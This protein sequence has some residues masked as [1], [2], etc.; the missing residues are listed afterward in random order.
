MKSYDYSSHA[1]YYDVVEASDSFNTFNQFL[2]NLFHKHNVKSVLDMTCGTGVQ[3]IFLHD[4]G[5][6][7]TA[8]DLSG[9]MISMAREKLGDRTDLQFHQANMI[10][11]NFNKQFEAVISMF[12]AIGHLTREDFRKTVQNAWNNLKSGGLYIFDIFN[13]DWMKENFIPHEFMDVCMEHEGTKYVRFNDNNLDFNTH[14]LHINQKTLIQTGIEKIREI[15]QIWDMQIYTRDE[16]TEL[17][18]EV[19]FE[20]V[21]V[22]NLEGETFDN[23]M[24]VVMIAQ[25]P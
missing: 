2:N 18:E 15:K 22:V 17:V 14:I 5:Y 11:V 13:F 7:V 3:S 23:N 25:K 21:S 10:D 24:F 19:G 12:N 4:N 1:R 16:L 9:E 6:E 20:V 8:S